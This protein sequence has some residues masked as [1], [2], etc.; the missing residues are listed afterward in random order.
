MVDWVMLSEYCHPDFC[1]S[2]LTRQQSMISIGF[3]T[4]SIGFRTISIGFCTIS[5]GFCTLKKV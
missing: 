1:T 3:C 4:I 5:I 2:I